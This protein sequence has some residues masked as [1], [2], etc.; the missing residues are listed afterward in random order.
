MIVSDDD[1]NPDV[2]PVKSIT[3]SPSSLTLNKG[4]S[5]DVAITLADEDGN[6]VEGNTVKTKL[7][8]AGKKRVSISSNSEETDENGEAVFTVTAKKKGKAVITFQSDSLKEKLKVKV[9]K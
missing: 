9:K 5:A 6:A 7:N 1:E 3:V 8:R 4:D 2:N